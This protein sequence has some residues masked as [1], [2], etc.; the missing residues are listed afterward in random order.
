M[1]IRTR[2][3]IL[4]GLVGT[5]FGGVVFLFFRLWQ[6]YEE[7]LAAVQAGDPHWHGMMNLTASQALWLLG[8]LTLLLLLLGVGAL[9]LVERHVEGPVHRLVQATRRFSSGDLRARVAP[10]RDPEMALLARTFNEMAAALA[11]QREDLFAQRDQLAWH[12]DMLNAMADA[13]PDA[14]VLVDRLGEIVYANAAYCRMVGRERDEL[15]G[16]KFRPLMRSWA[17]RTADPEGTLALLEGALAEWKA[18]GRADISLVEPERQ[19]LLLL[20]MP[21]R[22]RS[23]SVMGRLIIHRDMTREREIDRL[24][25]EMVSTVSHE[26]R[27][28]LAAIFGFAEL[29]LSGRLTGKDADESL[30]MI[31]RE[32]RRLNDLVS[33]FLDIQRLEQGREVFRCDW[34]DME[35][36]IQESLK[37]VW[38]G[39][40]QRLSFRREGEVPTVWADEVRISQVVENLLSNA[41]K[42]SPDGGPVEVLLRTACE[43]VRVEVADRGLGVPDEAKGL[44]FSRFYRIDSPDRKGIRGTGLG[45][46]IAGG[47]VRAHGGRIGVADREGGGSIFWFELPVRAMQPIGEGQLVAD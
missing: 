20:T 19:E 14:V 8:G 18:E 21:V 30:Q 31:Y 26:I 13:N 39:P 2:L 4:L 44:I 10:E 24:K 38:T 1:R 6:R 36:L 9:F 27:T 25:T 37:R 5:A 33:D 32:A 16:A 35:Q 7:L 40:E 42:Y 15:T 17:R 43:S 3:A 23:G 22:N 28:P 47:V 46:S 11:E 41:V 12:T 29:L 45:L 34:V